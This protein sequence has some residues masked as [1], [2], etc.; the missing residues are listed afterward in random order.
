ME[1]DESQ[2]ARLSCEDVRHPG[3]RHLRP[4]KP[5]SHWI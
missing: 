1:C 2:Q 3:R 4:S 5:L